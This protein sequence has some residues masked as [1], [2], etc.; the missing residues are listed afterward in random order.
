MIPIDS[1]NLSEAML[2]E[3]SA[4]RLAGVRD[5]MNR[6]ERPEYARQAGELMAD[7]MRE[8]AAIHERVRRLT[9]QAFEEAE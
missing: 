1:T 3:N 2:L 8:A 7:L 9:D 6:I 4:G 5:E